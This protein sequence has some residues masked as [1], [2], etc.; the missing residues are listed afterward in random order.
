MKVLRLDSLTFPVSA[1]ERHRLHEIGFTEVV[2]IQGSTPQEIIENGIDAEVVMVISNYLGADVIEGLKKCRAIM[3]R[4]TGCDKIDVDYATEKGIIVANLPD[5]ASSVVA[6]HALMLMLALARKLPV[7]QQAMESRDWIAIRQANQLTSLKGKTLGVV[8][9]GS[10]GKAIATRAKAFQMDIVDYHRHV[11]PDEERSYGVTPVSLHELLER[12]DFVTLA[13]PLTPETRHMFGASEFNLMK[14]SAY[15]VNIARGEL[16]DEEALAQALRTKTIAGAGIDVYE[17]LDMFSEADGQ[18]ACLYEDLENVI[19]TPHWAA[20]S[21]E[22]T[23]ESLDRTMEQVGM[24]AA[25]IFPTSCVNPE[26][27]EKVKDSF[28]IS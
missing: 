2:E 3:R 6:E 17:H 14:P 18:P 12:S 13:C 25:G 1:A 27:Y 7:M 26:V 16:C 11:R 10:I 21:K 5:F 28:T 23:Q 8:G 9:F 20:G 24:I 4:G 15:L 19:L 22:T